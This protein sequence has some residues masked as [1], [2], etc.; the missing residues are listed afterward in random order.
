MGGDRDFDVVVFGATGFVGRLV[1]RYLVRHA[2]SEL[3][4]GLAG[5]SE[6][7][8]RAVRAQL[9]AAASTWPL[10]L[11]DS[12]DAVSLARL[13]NAARVVVSTVGPY[14]PHGLAL[15]EAC[16]TAGTHYADLA[17]ELLFMRESIDRY[18]SVAA[19]TAHE[20]CIAAA[21]IPFPPT[22]GYCC[23]TRL[24]RRTAPATW[25]TRLCW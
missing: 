5:R 12:T 21:S 23:C 4:I 9:A 11:A 25:R 18:D 1:A 24:P 6:A 22:S 8:L 10:V 2:P 17:G 13:A 14:R 16:A 3:R 19:G 7:R 20:S 15:V